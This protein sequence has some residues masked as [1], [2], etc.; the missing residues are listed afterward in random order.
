MT[1]IWRGAESA[2]AISQNYAQKQVWK[3]LADV[4]DP[5]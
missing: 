3:Q 5:S 2:T 4:V 1:L